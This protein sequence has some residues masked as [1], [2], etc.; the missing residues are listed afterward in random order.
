[1]PWASY[2]VSADVATPAIDYGYRYETPIPQPVVQPGYGEAA[3]VSPPE[4]ID[5]SA[6]RATITLSGYAPTLLE[7][8]SIDFPYGVG[9]PVTT[10]PLTVVDVQDAIIDCTYL[11]TVYITSYAPD[12][13][14]FDANNEFLD[15]TAQKTI[16]L[17]G[18]A[19][20]VVDDEHIDIA[21]TSTVTLTGYAP[22][23]DDIALLPP[24]LSASDVLL[25]F[26]T[27]IET[28]PLGRITLVEALRVILAANSGTSNGV[29]T[30]LVEYKSPVS[31]ETM[32]IQANTIDGRNRSSTTINGA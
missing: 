7:I 31:P 3:P 12:L 15:L 1:L 4:D 18:F 17:S 32:R 5:L 8:E 29:G 2:G 20:D 27:P 6:L 16:I 26:N 14:E 22:S 9:L 21:G 23:V 19:P 30:N 24:V 10:Y 25:I 11:R 13:D 28:G